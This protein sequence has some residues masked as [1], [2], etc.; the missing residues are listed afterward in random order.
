MLRNPVKIFKIGFRQVLR[1]GMLLIL[2]PAPFLMAVA[3]GVLLP[4]ADQIIQ[5][6]T[7]IVITPWYSVSDALVLTM[8]PVMTAM[9]SAFLI[10][11]ERD[12]GIGVYYNITPAAGYSYLIARLALP[13]VWGLISSILVIA[14]FAFTVY[15]PL[16][17][18]TA[19]V[20]ATLQG[21]IMSMFLVT[22]AGNKVEGLALAKLTNIF[23]MG[24]IVPWVI[25]S[26][27]RYLFGFLP[28]FWLGE[29]LS[30]PGTEASLTIL[31]GL[32]GLLIAALWMILLM[33]LFLRRIS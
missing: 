24:F 11:E 28:G 22:V 23:V 3:M 4:L 26:P 30:S 20:I 32:G 19:S 10:L 1:D 12:E 31:H 29:I 5:E 8:T 2:I 17:I 13:M 15:S 33:K 16:E 21:G 6:Q 9:I 14:L 25:A 7:G 27:I 18:I